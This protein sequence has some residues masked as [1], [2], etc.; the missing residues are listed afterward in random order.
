MNPVSAFLLL[1]GPTGVGGSF[2]AVGP[3]LIVEVEEL[4]ILLEVPS[5]DTVELILAPE[6][7]EIITNAGGDMLI[8][9]IVE[10]ELIVDD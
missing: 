3:E 8:L 5:V 6:E 9:E 7:V 4:E 10:Q 1:T 2:F